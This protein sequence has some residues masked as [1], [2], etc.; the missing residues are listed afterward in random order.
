MCDHVERDFGRDLRTCH[1]PETL[2]TGKGDEEFILIDY[3]LGLFPACRM[4]K[5]DCKEYPH[6]VE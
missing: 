3:R 4:M 2:K 5:D 1:I 6:T